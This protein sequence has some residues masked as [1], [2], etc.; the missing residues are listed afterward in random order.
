M[1]TTTRVNTAFP[2]LIKPGKRT[3]HAMRALAHTE[4][5]LRRPGKERAEDM[6]NAMPTARKLCQSHS[7]EAR[8]SGMVLALALVLPIHAEGCRWILSG[9]LLSSSL[10]L[11]CTSVEAWE[12][13]TKLNNCSGPESRDFLVGVK[14]L[15]K[16]RESPCETI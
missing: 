3:T 5:I 8:A 10:S 2:R 7:T 11:P 6:K 14:S 15:L 9:N 4:Q 1:E 12:T 13:D 16:N